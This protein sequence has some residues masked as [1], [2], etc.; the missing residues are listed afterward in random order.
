MYTDVNDQRADSSDAVCVI[1]AGGQGKRMA[2]SGTHKACFPVGGTPAIFRAI[3]T[4]K[5]AGIKRF[6][7]VV[8]ELAEQVMSTVSPA[9]PDVAFAYQAEQRGTG[10][11]TL[12]GVD[13]LVAQGHRGPVI[14]AMGDSIVEPGVIRELQRTFDAGSYEAVIASA[15]KNQNRSSGR[16]VRNDAGE[17]VGV[18]E[19]ADIQLAERESRSL[20]V[21]GKAHDPKDLEAGADSVNVSLYAFRLESLRGALAQIGSDNAQ[22]EMYLTDTVEYLAQHGRVGELL[23]KD[24]HAV[25]A[26]NT[27]EELGAIEE[28]IADRY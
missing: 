6:L 10:H 27:P 18:V 2:S 1:L 25:M 28:V 20:N 24:P 23:V 13:V 16:V 12:V 7:V 14:V 21:G 3:D 4:Y 9:H 11:A 8:G 22:L 15:P 26:F 17:V 19:V 5:Q